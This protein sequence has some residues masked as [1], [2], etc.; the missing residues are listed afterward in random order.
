INNAGILRDMSLHKM[1]PEQWDLPL[2]V[3]LTGSYRVT[4]AA[5]PILRDKN[6]GRVIFTSSGAGLY[7]NFGQANYAAAKMRLVGL[8]NTLRIEGRKRGIL[9][10]PLAPVAASR[11]TAEVLPP[12]LLEVIKPEHVTPL[13][14]W[15]CHDSCAETGGLFEVGAGY[16]AKLR[17]E[18]T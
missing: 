8:A 5:W 6:Y 15:L 14:T 11:L 1:T 7:G 18:R 3:H 9:V 10:N 4:R 2:R 17:W 12:E 16:V 13:L